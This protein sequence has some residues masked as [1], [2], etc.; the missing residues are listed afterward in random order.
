MK[1][2]RYDHGFPTADWTAAKEEA[3]QAMVAAASRTGQIT[4]SEL[5]VGPASCRWSGSASCSEAVCRTR[6]E[7]GTAG[8]MRRVGRRVRRRV[9][10]GRR[11][12]GSSRSTWLERSV[13]GVSR[14]SERSRT[15]GVIL[16]ALVACRPDCD[17]QA[18]LRDAVPS[19]GWGVPSS[20]NVA[21][22]V[23]SYVVRVVVRSK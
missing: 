14:R 5:V 22:K 12:G 4:Y 17:R 6:R 19:A 15:L 18:V 8:P 3:R 2:E 10:A 21:R 9:R 20:V 23:R 7:Y 11:V 1:G 13:L 16:G